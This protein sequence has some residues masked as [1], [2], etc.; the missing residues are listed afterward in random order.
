M[1]AVREG[2]DAMKM[3]TVRRSA[4]IVLSG[5]LL[6]VCGCPPSGSGPGGYNPALAPTADRMVAAYEDLASKR[7][8]VIADFEDPAQATLFRREPARNPGG[9]EL[10]T[11]QAR[12]ET[13]VGSLRINLTDSSQRI[14][15]ADTPDG[16]WALHRDWTRFHLLLLSVY[17]PR[18]LTGFA[19]SVRSGTD[20]PLSYIHPRTA[21]NTGWN[22]IRVDLGLMADQVN[23]A[24]VRELKFW[25]DPLESPVELYLD[26]L[27][28]VNNAQQ[29][30]GPTE[31]AP[32]ELYV[33]TQGQRLVVGAAERFELVFSQGL[34][35]QWFDLSSDPA[36]THNLTGGGA[37]GPL[38]VLSAGTA[39]A[40]PAGEPQ[41]WA[42][43]GVHVT[44][45][46]ALEEALPLRVVVR[47]EWRLGEADEPAHE[48]A[49]AHHWLY[50]V[51]RDGRIYV[52]W[53][54]PAGEAGSA[55]CC[56]PDAGFQRTIVDRATA[57]AD[58]RDAYVLFSR[59]ERG[60]ADLLFAP[61]GSLPAREYTH[62][63]DPRLCVLCPWPA[64]QERTSAAAMLRVWPADI[65]SP[66]Q[67]GPMASDYRN[68]LPIAVDAG[69]LV[70][71]DPGD[72]DGDGFSEGR[73]YFALQLDGSIAKVR[74][75]GRQRMRFSPTFKLVGVANRDVWAYV[76]G[77]QIETY[78][79]RQNDALFEVKG[80]I[81]GEALVE[82][83]SRTRDGRK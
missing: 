39:E 26:D 72:L 65:D 28:L 61:F 18:K 66:A 48:S 69:S 8:Q 12:R 71:N 15:A 51:Y 17:S 75:G 34:I 76:D 44:V 80:M 52:E 67:A 78:R 73:G 64:A 37:L 33:R 63:E 20:V 59:E 77:R 16:Q 25:C 3:R 29:V 9:V 13:G 79:D 4:A 10:S 74:V 55:V 6:S 22:L 40:A 43:P 24:D 19:F 46:Q 5:W 56:D 35:R 32:G 36:M 49:A 81:T 11:Q 38:P 30:F 31:P 47:G 1:F 2:S 23:L 7:F 14:I 53:S 58:G 57:E 27:L 62:P 60:R 54:G 45:E 42:G 68:P 50:S 41:R 83:T 21:L 70:R 82:V